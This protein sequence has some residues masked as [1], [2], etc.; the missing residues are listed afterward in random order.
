LE[1]AQTTV[2]AQKDKL[3]NCRQQQASEQEEHTRAEAADAAKAQEVAVNEQAKAEVVRLL[4]GMGQQLDGDS[5]VVYQTY[6]KGVNAE[7]TLIAAL[8]SALEKESSQRCGFD[9]VAMEHL[10]N[11]LEHKI[12]E[13]DAAIAAMAVAKANVHAEALGAWAIRE[14][15]GEHVQEAVVELEA[16][17]AAVA[18]GTEQL[19][20][21]REAEQHEEA[22]LAH[23]LTDLTLAGEKLRQ[24]GDA[25]EALM[26]VEAGPKVVQ[27][28][29]PVLATGMD[30][31]VEMAAEKMDTS[32]DVEMTLPVVA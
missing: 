7:P 5:I 31:D 32:M 20:A 14:L 11:I 23:Y 8:R 29:A 28:A 6:L 25:L 10:K 18:A 9:C 4:E 3:D 2:K 13:W 16:A 12:R 1:A 17:E 24:C 27:E 26:S 21:A 22:V 30:V 19:N 15:A